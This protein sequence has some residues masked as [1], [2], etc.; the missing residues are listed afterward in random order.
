[1]KPSRAEL[2]IL[3]SHHTPPPDAGQR[4]GIVRRVLLAAADEV[5]D[6]IPDCPEVELFVNKMCEAMYHANAGIARQQARQG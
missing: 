2:S 1:M 5:L 6:Q 3:F 4:I